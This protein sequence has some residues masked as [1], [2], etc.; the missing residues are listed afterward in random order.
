MDTE[1]LDTQQL[2]LPYWEDYSNFR[3]SPDPAQPVRLPEP[4]T[5]AF[6]A[7]LISGVPQTAASVTG[8]RTLLLDIENSPNLAYVY[9]VWQTD[10]HADMLQETSEVISFAYKW[11]GEDD[12]GFYSK[13]HNGKRPMILKA[14]ELLNEADVVMTYYGKKHDV[15]HLNTEFIKIEYPPPSPFKHIDLYDTVKA[16]FNFTYHSLDF[17]CKQ[18]GLTGK[19][20]KITFPVW[21]AAIKGSADAWEQIKQ[22]NIGDVQALEDLYNRVQPWVKSHPS[23]AVF[24]G[25]HVCPSC[26]SS[27]LQR[28]G[29]AHTAVSVYQRWQCQDCGAW[30]RTTKRDSGVRIRQEVS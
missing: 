18:L 27:N 9:K 8:P 22:Y 2:Q 11:L 12:L 30:S 21:L 25:N 10:I 29:F 15:P 5:D 7:E 6:P 24:T 17:V 20:D 13:Y 3:F 4:D 14:W 16:R 28:R 1:I 19:T 26:G 23:W